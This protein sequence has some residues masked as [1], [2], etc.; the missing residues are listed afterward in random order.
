MQYL[1]SWLYFYGYLGYKNYQFI[2]KD[3]NNSLIHII[4]QSNK[5]IN[6]YPYAPYT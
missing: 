5:N 2:I 6:P 4:P 3:I 1:F